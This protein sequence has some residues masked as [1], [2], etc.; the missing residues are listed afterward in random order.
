LYTF[1]ITF[2]RSPSIS[3]EAGVN[4]LEREGIVDVNEAELAK[5]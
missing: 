5:I 4:V 1:I 2:G 3:I